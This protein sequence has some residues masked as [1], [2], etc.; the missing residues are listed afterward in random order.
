MTTHLLVDFGEVI[1]EPQPVAA[2][3]GMAA[4]V[5]MPTA[6]FRERYWASRE[7]Y[8]RGLPAQEYWEDVAGRGVRGGELLTLRRLDIES[9][10][11]LNFATITA[12]RIA[13][14]RG[15][16]LTLLSNAPSDL[17]DEVRGSAVLGELFSLMVFSAELR[18][19]KPD[20]EIFDTALALAE[21]EPGATLFIDDRAENL[22][23][24]RGRG[25]RTHEF[26]T[27]TALHDE[28]TAIDL[29]TPLRGFRTTS[30]G[31]R[32]GAK[33]P[34]HRVDRPRRRG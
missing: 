2:V 26:R 9:W 30:P 34:F 32:L 16:Q 18:L 12:L 22:E 4:V 10:T 24:A 15:A 7:R 14:R 21:V 11:H 6:T 8:D 1:S 17:A 20:G 25:I 5:G 27:A 3:R 23:S 13:H 33:H 31:S 28:L 29:G 19:A